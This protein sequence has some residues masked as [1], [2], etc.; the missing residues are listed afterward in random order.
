MHTLIV[1]RNG[2]NMSELLD[3]LLR[4]CAQ[5]MPLRGYRSVKE[6]PDE[7]GNAPIYM[8]PAS[9][10]RTQRE[11]NL[12]GWCRNEDKKAAPGN[13]DRFAYLLDDAPGCVILMDEIGTMESHSKRFADAILARLDGDTPVLAAVRDKDTPFLT[14][15]RS[16]PNVR[17]F[18]MRDGAETVFREASAFFGEQI[19]RYREKDHVSV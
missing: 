1:G 9:G 16:H 2:T 13:L 11:E 6:A 4:E 18:T 3:R 14:A 19:R 12:L 15:V 17:C 10:E 8:Y 5:G 7:T